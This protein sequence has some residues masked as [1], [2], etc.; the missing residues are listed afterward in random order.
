MD[1]TNDTSSDSFGATVDILS[2][3]EKKKQFF[4]DTIIKLHQFSP[5]IKSPNKN[6]L[7]R[8]RHSKI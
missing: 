7:K 6:R 3:F 2:E 5:L 4:E 8:D 1:S